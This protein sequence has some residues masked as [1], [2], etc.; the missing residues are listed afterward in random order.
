VTEI[1]ITSNSGTIARAWAQAP[2]FFIEEAHA[3]VTEGSLLLE[4][5]TNE[6]TPTSGAGT[7]RDGIAA[8]PVSIGDRA[9]TGGVGTAISYAAA[10]EL[11]AKPHWMPIEPL[12]DW[13]RRKLAKRGD[14]V[15]E[16]ARM[17]WF[18]IAH[19]GTR[20]RFMFRDAA[21]AAEAQIVTMLERAAERA[22]ERLEAEAR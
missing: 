9:V 4:R 3:A 11:G 18:K 17:V 14:E 7:L 13:V 6:R 8:I 22:L 12:E 16:V 15:Q 21:N 10:V 2:D 20:G 1:K 5:E 19:R